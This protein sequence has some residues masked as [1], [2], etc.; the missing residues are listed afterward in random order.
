MDVNVVEFLALRLLRMMKNN[1]YS[2]KTLG[3]LSL[4]DMEN[5]EKIA[6]VRFRVNTWMRKVYGI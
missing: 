1:D 5:E 3:P 6:K 4:L 2:N